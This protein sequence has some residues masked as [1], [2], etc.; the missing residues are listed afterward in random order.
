LSERIRWRKHGKHNIDG[1]K[2]LG[3][4]IY[5]SLYEVIKTWKNTPCR[6]W[7]RQCRTFSYHAMDKCCLQKKVI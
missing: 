6:Y 3:P 2:P 5:D 4:S 1:A 7:A